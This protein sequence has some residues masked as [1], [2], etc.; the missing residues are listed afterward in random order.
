MLYGVAVLCSNAQRSLE[1][2]YGSALSLSTT[3]TISQEITNAHIRQSS[4]GVCSPLFAC[5]RSAITLHLISNSRS[6]VKGHA[7]SHNLLELCIT[8]CVTVYLRVYYSI[9]CIKSLLHIIR[10][11]TRVIN[12]VNRIKSNQ[13]IGANHHEAI[14][15]YSQCVVHLCSTT[16]SNHTHLYAT[17]FI[18]QPNCYDRSVFQ[19]T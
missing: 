11:N 10:Y 9:Y 17:Y 3:S 8:A 1:H 14:S 12:Q 7:A 19:K 4:F 16:V 6:S 15:Q 5:E 13:S 18:T 2:L